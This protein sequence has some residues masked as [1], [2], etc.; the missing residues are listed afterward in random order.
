MAKRYK[1]EKSSNKIKIISIFIW[2]LFAIIN[3][4]LI[5]NIIKIDMIPTN[6]LV[7][8]ISA[9][10]ILVL[11]ILLIIGL[12]KKGIIT[13]ICLDIFMILV[14][15]IEIYAGTKLNTVTEFLNNQLEAKYMTNVYNVIV[16]VDSNYNSLDDI[17]NKDIYYLNEDNDQL[18]INNINENI[19]NAKIIKVSDITDIFKN[20]Q[21]D[22]TYI[23]IMNSGNYDT[24]ISNDENIEKNVKIIGSFEIKTEI[25]TESRDIDVTK[26]PFVIL[27]NGIDTRSGK[28]PA[29]SLSDVNIIMAVNPKTNRILMIHVPRDY[30]VEV[31]EKK[32]A[33]DKLTHTGSIGGVDL[34]KKTLEELLEMDIQYYARANFNAVI[35]LVDAIGGIDVFSDVDYSFHSYNLPALVIKPGYNHLNGKEALAF[36]KERH[37]YKD[38]DRHRGENQEQVI[39]CVINKMTSSKTLLTNFDKIFESVKGTFETNFELDNVSALVKMQISEMPKWSIE[40]CNVTGT[41]SE[42]YTFSYPKQKLY[43]MKPDMTSIENAINK[44]NEVLEEK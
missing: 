8:G 17:A 36:A 2:V 32:G 16:N 33:K 21:K 25:K 43:V 6:F 28:L 41:G 19:K 24:I 22:K 31:S 30:Y 1:N 34:T 9:I 40:N 20:L 7:I 39:K 44:L 23:S 3:L 29:R 38:G 14:S 4:Y 27:V 26:D 13:F 12:K 10:A 37:A 42:E 15:C 35:N 5:G 18:V 11:L